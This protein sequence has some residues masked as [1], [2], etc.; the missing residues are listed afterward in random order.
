M[1]EVAVPKVGTVTLAA[2]IEGRQSTPPL[3]PS[4]ENYSRP[5]YIAWKTKKIRSRYD[6]SVYDF[7]RDGEEWAW[8]MT[9]VINKYSPLLTDFD[10]RE[11]L[12]SL[13]SSIIKPAYTDLDNLGQLQIDSDFEYSDEVVKAVIGYYKKFFDPNLDV[14]LS[15]PRGKNTGYPTPAIASSRRRSDILL[16]FH[17]AL[18][19]GAKKQK[20]SL[21]DLFQ[22]LQPYHGEAF[23]IR[24]ER[25]QDSGKVFPARLR[26]GLFFTKNLQ[27]RV[28]EIYFSPKFAVIWNRKAAK[29]ALAAILKSDIHTPMKPEIQAKITSWMNK[30]WK[31][32]PLDHSGYDRHHGGRRGEQI[33]RV[34]AEAFN[35]SIDDLLEEMKV[36]IL[37][38]FRGEPVLS[39]ELEQLP[40]GISMTTVLGCVG[41]LCSMVASMS[42]LLQLSPSQVMEKRGELW[43]CL[44][45]GDDTLIA[46][47]PVTGL[48]HVDQFKPAFERL[49]LKIDE[50]AV[51]RY[52]GVVY[53]G[54][55]FD[56]SYD[57]GY[58]VG[59]AVSLMYSPERVK[60]Y[61]FNVIGYIARLELL[62][63]KGKEFHNMT[64]SMWPSDFKEP[65]RFEDRHKVLRELVKK[66]ARSGH[67]IGLLDDVF[68]ILTH[69]L[70]DEAPGLY[71]EDMDIAD[72]LG[73]THVDLEDPVEAAVRLEISKGLVNDLSK[74]ISDLPRY[75]DHTLTSLVNHEKLQWRPNDLV[76]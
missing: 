30:K 55:T 19:S 35:M 62:K 72:L 15:M 57:L 58:P 50:E 7:V 39:R 18:V 21:S 17:A 43:D 69:G 46:V 1:L 16:T 76:F 31:I 2:G 63:T 64:L 14:S 52:L 73:V 59:R 75:Y 54:G 28:R 42:D 49:K 6:Q 25:L 34:A 26:E 13:C 38:W 41:N 66:A 27:K 74:L 56:G 45:Y 9:T 61:P 32:F 4:F 51:I 48:T 53:G 68:N 70:G 23:L 11:V 71:P 65:F 8:K 33:A 12:P 36:P 44:L 60:V 37:S 3:S 29:R 47:N 10:N 5:G 22:F 20:L 40:S 24:G 67:L